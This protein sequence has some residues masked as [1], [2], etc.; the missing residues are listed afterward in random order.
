[1]K[2]TAFVFALLLA[3]TLALS[4]CGTAPQ[5]PQATCQQIVEALQA[6]ADFQPLTAMTDK[7]IEKYLLV[8]G[9][10]LAQA[11]MLQDAT[12]AT[13]EMILALAA[14]DEKSADAVQQA[15]QDFLEEQRT[16]YRDYQPDE[17]PKL[18][19]A[20]VQRKGTVIVLAVSPDAEKTDAA[21]AAVW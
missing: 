3:L 5:K 21:L 13:P 10:Q 6:A 14:A 8:E 18:E 11:V 1:M 15:V 17:M 12:R 20:R 7:Y 9:D 2:K 16:A 19:K 4:G